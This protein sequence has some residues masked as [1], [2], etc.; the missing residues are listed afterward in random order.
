MPSSIRRFRRRHV[1]LGLALSVAAC[2]TVGQLNI[3]SE[4]QELEMGAQ[5][6]AELDKTLTFIDDPQV[7]GYVD[8]LGQSIAHASQRNNIPYRFRV[9]NTDEVNAFAVPGGYL[10]VNRGLLETADTE[11]EAAGVL[12]HEIGHVVGR[13]SA[14]Q[15]T[16][17]YGISTISALLLGQNPSM[18]AQITAQF[19][20]TGAI[21]SY[22]REMESEADSYGVQELYDAGIDPN[23]LATFFD[24]L[25]ALRG[26]AASSKVETFFSTHP[27]P[28]ARASTVRAQIAKLP[29]KPN[30]RKD[31]PNF[32]EVKAKL[33]S[34]PKAPPPPA[35]PAK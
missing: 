20:A 23:G 21:L 28:G 19:V 5:F 29:P 9:V 2:A 12:G 26:G 31:S 10:F 33:K 11:C 16:Q 27:D 8:N 24:K 13:H 25:V 34:M 6:A 17:Q 35:A 15:M 14:R 7:V 18:V 1:I 4:Q 22:S 3:V 32:Q 30:L